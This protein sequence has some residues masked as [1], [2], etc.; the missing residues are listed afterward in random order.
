LRVPLT[1]VRDRQVWTIE[2]RRHDGK[3]FCVSTLTAAVVPQ[4]TVPT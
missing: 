1:W 4:V 3:L 2:L